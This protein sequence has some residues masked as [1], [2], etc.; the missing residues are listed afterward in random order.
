MSKDIDKVQKKDDNFSD[1][2][3]TVNKIDGHSG[4]RL[5]KDVGEPPFWLS[6]GDDIFDLIISNRKNGGVPGGRITQ[7]NGLQSC[8]TQDTMVKIR[9]K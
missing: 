4:A 1:I 9:V 3:K 8:V 6:T 7:L 5:V 2:L